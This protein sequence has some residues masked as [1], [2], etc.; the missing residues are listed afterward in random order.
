[1][2]SQYINGFTDIHT[3]LLPGVDDGAKSM[4]EALDLVTM[5]WNNGTRT[6]FLTPHYRG[7]YKRNS[8]A[9]LKEK[10]EEFSQRVHQQLPEM[11]LYLGSEIHYQADIP[12]KLMG[13]EVLTMNESGFILLEF[14]QNSWKSQVLYAVSDVLGC[15]LTP[16]IAHAERYD[17]FRK[18]ATLADEVLQMG[19]KIQLN[20]DSVMGKHGFL[21][22][23]YCR[24]LL[25]AG[26]VDFIASDAHD[27]TSRTPI[28]RE[29]FLH[30]HKKYGAE[31]AAAL[32]YHNAQ[33]V[34]TDTHF[35]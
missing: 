27:L 10:F 3:H 19:A 22:K 23:H 29:C 31:N 30:I 15:G 26:K 25:K 6:I 8:P 11:N 5:A 2:N 4:D 33:N 17:I 12:D 20:A 13:E 14:S 32:F 7:K 18:D 1:M 28:L 34:I 9:F 24:K 16:I 35:E 21:V